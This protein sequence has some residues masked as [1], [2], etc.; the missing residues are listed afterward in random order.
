MVIASFRLKVDLST[1]GGSGFGY[2]LSEIERELP[3]PVSTGETL[4]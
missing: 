2:R 4:S 3:D 1:I